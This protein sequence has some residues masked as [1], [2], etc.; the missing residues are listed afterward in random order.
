M[1]EPNFHFGEIVELGVGL[2]GL[3]IW[4]PDGTRRTT[5]G[6]IVELHSFIVAEVVV[7][8]RSVV[9]VQFTCFAD[10]HMWNWSFPLKG[11]KFYHP[12]QYHRPGWIS[13]VSQAM[14]AQGV[15]CSGGGCGGCD[16][17]CKPKDGCN[18]CEECG[19]KGCGRDCSGNCES[20]KCSK[21]KKCDCPIDELMNGGCTCGG[22]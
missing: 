6:E 13:R 15:G 22:A 2:D 1:I 12:K 3:P 9:M 10:G 5:E 16:T 7:H 8:P 4:L 17:G 20:C 19:S 18:G 11:D 21:T 14:A